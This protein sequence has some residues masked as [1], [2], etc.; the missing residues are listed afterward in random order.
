MYEDYSFEIRLL[1]TVMSSMKVKTTNTSPGQRHWPSASPAVLPTSPTPHMSSVSFH[2][3]TY[4]AS[5]D[6]PS[7]HPVPRHHRS[8]SQIFTPLFRINPTN[9]RVLTEIRDEECSESEEVIR[10]IL[11]EKTSSWETQSQTSM[12]NL[13]SSMSHIL[14]LQAAEIERKDKARARLRQEVLDLVRSPVT[15]NSRPDSPETVI[16]IKS[17]AAS[18]TTVVEVFSTSEDTAIPVE[19]EKGSDFDFSLSLAS[20]L[21]NTVI[22]D[23]IAHLKSAVAALYLPTDHHRHTLTRLLDSY[24]SSVPCVLGFL[25]AP[26]RHAICALYEL[27][28]GIGLKKVY[29][30]TSFPSR[31]GLEV[32]TCYRFDDL[33]DDFVP[34]HGRRVEPGV[35]AVVLQ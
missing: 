11:R 24:H 23:R 21:E 29:G 35:D 2:K 10:R 16:T 28:A 26:R 4:S 3:R 33:S 32:Q 17:S 6:L 15:S 18:V 22:T 27:N 34:L 1:D 25:S 13:R 14:T 31:V 8:S 7:S 5:H 19:E 30:L 20:D 12:L 9:R